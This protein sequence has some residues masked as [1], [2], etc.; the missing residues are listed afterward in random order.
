[1]GTLHFISEFLV[2]GNQAE[3]LGKK[4]QKFWNIALDADI[5]VGGSK[6]NRNK[7]HGRENLSM[8]VVIFADRSTV[9][10]SATGKTSTKPI[11]VCRSFWGW[12]W[13]HLARL[14]QWCIPSRT[15]GV[16]FAVID[17]SRITGLP[18]FQTSTRL[19]CLSWNSP[20]FPGHSRVFTKE[21]CFI[22]TFFSKELS[23]EAQN[24][25]R[26]VSP[27]AWEFSTVGSDLKELHRQKTPGFMDWWVTSEIG[28]QHTPNSGRSSSAKPVFRTEESQIQIPAPVPRALLFTW[29][30]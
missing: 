22:V 23:L 19:Y 16:I 15:Q 14:P 11:E 1:M 27:A 26:E 7:D 9:Y 25:S 29:D 21:T 2:E 28:L 24:R 18:D 17:R 3:V 10:S 4:L 5:A 13:G 6:S 12:K 30:I 8:P 20:T